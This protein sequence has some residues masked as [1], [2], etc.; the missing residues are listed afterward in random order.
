DRVAPTAVR[1]HS[2]DA[3][4]FTTGLTDREVAI[5]ELIAAGLSNDQIAA[6]LYVS[7]NTVKTH[8][9][10]AYKRIGAQS[11]SQAVIWAMRHGLGPQTEARTANTPGARAGVASPP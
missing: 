11:R 4:R 5:L 1:A 6:K 7:I 10:A 9:R 3:A 2:R 8:V